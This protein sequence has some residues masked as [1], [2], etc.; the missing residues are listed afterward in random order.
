MRCSFS[1]DGE[2]HWDAW[3]IQNKA[4]L[5]QPNLLFIYLPGAWAFQN[6]VILIDCSVELKGRICKQMVDQSTI[7]KFY[8]TN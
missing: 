3:D 7:R 8:F 4:Q 2:E 6:K 5:K 1:Q